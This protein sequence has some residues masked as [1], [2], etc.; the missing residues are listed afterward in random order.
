LWDLSRPL[1]GPVDIKAASKRFQ[2]M[3]GAQ[4]TILCQRQRPPWK[5]QIV[6]T[7]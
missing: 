1:P 6:S 2:G 4:D 7:I 3:R 5:Q